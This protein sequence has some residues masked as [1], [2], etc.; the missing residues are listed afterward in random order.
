[1]TYFQEGHRPIS[2]ESRSPCKLFVQYEYCGER[3]REKQRESLFFFLLFVLVKL[4]YGLGASKVCNAHAQ[5]P[6]DKL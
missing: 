2:I 4:H 5:I 1:M 6:C 3:K